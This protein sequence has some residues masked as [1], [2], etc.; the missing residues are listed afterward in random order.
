MFNFLNILSFILSISI[1][2]INFFNNQ[3]ALA[4]NK[5][6]SPVKIE[7]PYSNSFLF[8]RLS[9][10]SPLRCFRC[11][12]LLTIEEK[13]QYDPFNFNKSN[14]SYC[15]KCYDLVYLSCSDCHKARYTHSILCYL[16]P[17]IHLCDDCFE[18]FIKNHTCFFCRKSFSKTDKIYKASSFYVCES[19]YPKLQPHHLRGAY[20]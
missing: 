8:D 4:I 2:F 20:G 18:K 13:K 1:N 12:E 10:A 7:D 14:N 19:C 15:S 17:S 16:S 5:I 6:K 3:L 9:E 11:N